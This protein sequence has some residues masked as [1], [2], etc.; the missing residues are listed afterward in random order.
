MP[1]KRKRE[2]TIN[3]D[4]PFKRR[5]TCPRCTKTVTNLP[6]HLDKQPECREFYYANNQLCSC[7]AIP[8]SAHIIR[9]TPSS[10]P[11]APS[12]IVKHNNPKYHKTTTIQPAVT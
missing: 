7:V 1:P 5:Q 4:T 3:N 9:T 12:T 6:T 8:S 11:V 2:V 10:L